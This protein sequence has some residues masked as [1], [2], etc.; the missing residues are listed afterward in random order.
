MKTIQI[1]TCLSLLLIAI[2][3]NEAKSQEAID[4]TELKA[5]SSP[6]FSILGVQPNDIARPKTFEALEANL[7][8]SISGENSTILPNNYAL[9]F[10]PYW[11]MSHPKLQYK[12]MQPGFGQTIIQNASFSVAT[13]QYKNSED[14]ATIFSKMGFGFRTMLVE[15]KT[16]SKVQELVLDQLQKRVVLSQVVLHMLVENTQLTDLSDIRD[17][18]ESEFIS[19][20]LSEEQASQDANEIYQVMKQINDNN[21]KSSSIVESRKLIEKTSEFLIADQENSNRIT[22]AAKSL[23][24]ANL[25][26]KGFMIELAGALVLDFPENNTNY[27]KVTKYAVWLTPGYR[28]KDVNGKSGNIIE[29]LGVMRYLR[30]EAAT[31]FSD[32]IDL[33]L[34]AGIGIKKL[35]FSGEIIH[36]FQR[37]LVSE[38]T[39]NGFITKTTKSLSDTRYD[40]NIEYKLSDK[41][42]LAYTFG[43]NFTF[44]TEFAGN[45]ISVASLNF[46]FGG[47]KTELK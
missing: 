39:Q 47:P 20:G 34:R 13:N 32:N 6:A 31:D 10:S 29:L 26:K 28:F 41:L 30:N 7:F 45:L 23:Q 19:A 33:G 5:P 43:Q 40:F 16:D 12:Q 2:F 24:E 11:L 14:T 25:D 27:S 21:N 4:L 46:G 1:Y 36:R 18:I 9:E 37:V 42:V 17:T 22:N 38:T 15:G 44:N 8:S 3:S 35:S